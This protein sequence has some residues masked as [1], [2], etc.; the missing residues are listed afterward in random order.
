MALTTPTPV[1]MGRDVDIVGLKHRKQA[2]DNDDS[3]NGIENAPH[4]SIQTNVRGID[5]L[6]IFLG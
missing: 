5:F 4:K 1:I 6:P 3:L 2:D